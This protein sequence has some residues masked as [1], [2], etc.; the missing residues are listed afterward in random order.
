VN[1][2]ASVSPTTKSHQELLNSRAEIFEV[3]FNPVRGEHNLHRVA[4]GPDFELANI[5][6][7]FR[8][9]ATQLLEQV[10]AVSQ[11]IQQ[12]RGQVFTRWCQVRCARQVR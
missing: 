1:G 11:Q 9:E 7:R 5:R 4:R 6:Y 8:D 3:E 12:N 10:R 2:G